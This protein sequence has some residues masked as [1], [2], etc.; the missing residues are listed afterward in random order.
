MGDHSKTSINTMF[1]TGTSVGFS[2]NIFGA[3]FPS[4]H[5]PSFSWG[6]SEELKTYEV[7]KSIETAAK[8]FKRRNKVMTEAD[9][10]LFRKVFELTKEERKKKGIL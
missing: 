10:Y 3:G 2:C 6:G 4:K 7:E 8:V 5:M 1:N 9:D